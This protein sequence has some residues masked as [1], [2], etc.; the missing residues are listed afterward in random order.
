MAR[1]ERY[2]QKSNS[3]PSSFFVYYMTAPGDR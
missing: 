2:G 3:T 1:H